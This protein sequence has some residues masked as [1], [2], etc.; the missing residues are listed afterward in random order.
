MI[1]SIH[2]IGLGGVWIG[3]IFNQKDEV[4]KNLDIKNQK[5]ELLGTIVLG[6]PVRIGKSSRKKLESF[7]TW[8]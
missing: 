1:L 7:V 2:D 8:I 4:D 6:Y 5:F 3:E